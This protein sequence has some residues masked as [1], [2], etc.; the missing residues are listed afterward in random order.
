MHV[1]IP[2]AW[3]KGSLYLIGI[4]RINLEFKGEYIIAQIGGGFEKFELYIAKN[5]RM[6]ER[7]LLIKMLQSN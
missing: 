1:T 5:H 6:L 4:N 2:I 3:I 7:Q